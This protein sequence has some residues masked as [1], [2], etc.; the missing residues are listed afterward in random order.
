MAT[1]QEIQVGHDLAYFTNKAIR[2]HWTTCHLAQEVH[3]ITGEPWLYK[4]PNINKPILTPWPVGLLLSEVTRSIDF[5]IHFTSRVDSFIAKADSK[6]VSEGLKNYGLL[7]PDIISDTQ[8]INMSRSEILADKNLIQDKKNLAIL[9][10]QKVIS[11]WQIDK[12]PML[13]VKKPEVIKLINGAH[14][15]LDHLSYELKGISGDSGTPHTYT[16]E[17]MKNL[18]RERCNVA[19]IEA[20]ASGHPDAALILQIA[21]WIT[22]NK[23]ESFQT[24]SDYIDFNLPKLPVVRRHWAL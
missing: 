23:D 3:P 24:M 1:R 22:A 9:G 8:K 6:L 2:W 12:V 7:T 14:G 21:N 17:H 18:I 19:R 4:D 11:S 13:F 5:L 16:E 15:V 10:D 20:T